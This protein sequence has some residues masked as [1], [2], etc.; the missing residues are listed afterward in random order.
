MH[1][2]VPGTE[3]LT[4]EQARVVKLITAP[5]AAQHARTAREQPDLDT[6]TETPW[7]CPR[8]KKQYKRLS[9]ARRH[10]E[11]NECRPKRRRRARRRRTNRRPALT[12]SSV[13]ADW[14]NTTVH[15]ILRR[16]SDAETRWTPRLICPQCRVRASRR[17]GPCHRCL[18][19]QWASLA[20]SPRSWDKLVYGEESGSHVSARRAARRR[21]PEAMWVDPRNREAAKARQDLGVWLHYGPRR[22]W[23][24]ELIAPRGPEAALS[25]AHELQ[26]HRRLHLLATLLTGAY[27]ERV[28][29]RAMRILE[30]M[31]KDAATIRDV[32]RGDRRHVWTL[33][34]RSPST[35]GPTLLPLPVVE[36]LLYGGGV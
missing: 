9:A 4:E 26:P 17:D 31:T 25:H 29:S 35:A 28:R 19:F 10:A 2:G 6:P 36:R 27:P 5:A 20:Q 32:P 11:A 3:Q 16:D 15:G 18:Y 33:L 1:T 24:A 12:H 13:P 14:M 34:D 8:C 30:D 22:Q 21:P 7:T 23:E